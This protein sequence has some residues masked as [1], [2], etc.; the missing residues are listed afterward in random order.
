MNIKIPE[1]CDLG[2]PVFVCYRVL[3]EARA[4]VYSVVTP[5]K[6]KPTGFFYVFLRTVHKKTLTPIGTDSA[7]DLRKILVDKLLHC[8]VG[9]LILHG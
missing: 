4:R 2:L 1:T 6:S 9:R 8:T 3:L 5:L 7:K